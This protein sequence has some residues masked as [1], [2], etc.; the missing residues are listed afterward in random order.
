[1]K[2]GRLSVRILKQ[3]NANATS[4][5]GVIALNKRVACFVRSRHTNVRRQ[6]VNEKRLNF[7]TKLP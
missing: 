1:M 7:V 2:Q 5:D 4:G 6:L 3:K